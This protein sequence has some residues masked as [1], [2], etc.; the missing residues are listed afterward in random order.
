M[1]LLFAC[2]LSFCNGCDCDDDCDCEVAAFQRLLVQT[3]DLY[4]IT[5]DPLGVFD[6]GGNE[7]LATNF[8]TPA[9]YALLQRRANLWFQTEFNINTSANKSFPPF[10]PSSGVVQ[11]LNATGG[12]IGISFPYGVGQGN[13]LKIAF[14]SDHC[15]WGEDG[16]KVFLSFG[17]FIQFQS[18]GSL[19]TRVGIQYY[20][21]GDFILDVDVWMVTKNK[22][23][24][25]W[26]Y[27]GEE[28]LMV[29]SSEYISETVINSQRR[30][31]QLSKL[32]VWTDQDGY[33]RGQ[34][35]IVSELSEYYAVLPSNVGTLPVNQFHRGVYT[36]DRC[37]FD[38]M[39]CNQKRR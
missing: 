4:N 33:G 5:V 9:S 31:E 11:L 26:K 32:L 10:P 39:G 13:T 17:R 36:W 35:S 27:P 37:P 18:S 3:S 14:D 12:P 1:L 30:Q 21:P 25:G 34:L 19:Q 7:A 23:V 15:C 24:N 29:A 6:L 2:L 28:G 20:E 22:T 8:Y 38:N 16:N